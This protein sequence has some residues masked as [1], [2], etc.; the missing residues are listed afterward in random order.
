[1]ATSQNVEI[2]K[3]GY[4]AFGAGDIETVL[5]DYDDDVEF[6]V[7]GNSAI[8]GTY[9]GKAGSR[10]CSRRWPSGPLQ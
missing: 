6:V 9:R 4:A 5:S 1:M 10:N 3:K 7:R 8:S 2:S